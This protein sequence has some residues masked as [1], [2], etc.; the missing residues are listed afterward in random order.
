MGLA[1]FLLVLVSQLLTGIMFANQNRVTSS[2]GHFPTDV[3]PKNTTETLL[4]LPA[5]CFYP[6]GGLPANAT[7]SKPAVSKFSPGYRLWIATMSAYG[8]MFFLSIWAFVAQERLRRK[9]ITHLLYWSLQVFVVGGT[10]TVAILSFI[11]IQ[12]L[13]AWMADSG[14]IDKLTGHNPEVT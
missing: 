2:G 12:R 1:R 13:R 9:S 10:T 6:S 7:Q 4:T 14:L 3:P 5:A 8:L 11:H